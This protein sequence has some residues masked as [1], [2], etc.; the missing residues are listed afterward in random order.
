MDSNRKLALKSSVFLFSEPQRARTLP[1]LSRVAFLIAN[2]MQAESRNDQRSLLG[3]ENALSSDLLGWRWAWFIEGPVDDDGLLYP[4]RL[5]PDIKK[6]TARIVVLPKQRRDISISGVS[7]LISTST[8]TST[9]DRSAASLSSHV[10]PR[11]IPAFPAC[12]K[13]H[14]YRSSPRFFPA[15]KADST[16]T[17]R[18]SAPSEAQKSEISRVSQANLCKKHVPHFA[19]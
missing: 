3:S 8:V 17:R 4:T 9:A 16:G 12:Y 11:N 19:P 13:Q 7:T 5:V 14:R 1:R 15:D 2:R 10:A 18:T 6:G